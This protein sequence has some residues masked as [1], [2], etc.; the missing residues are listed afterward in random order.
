MVLGRTLQADESP[1]FVETWKEME[2]L[3]DEGKPSRPPGEAHYQRYRTS[4]DPL[5]HPLTHPR[6]SEGHRGVQL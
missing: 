3:L 1:T 4:P 6:Q 2:K 5:T